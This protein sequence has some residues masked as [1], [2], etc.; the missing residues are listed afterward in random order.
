M[1]TVTTHYRPKRTPRKKRKQPPLANRIVTAKL[2]PIKEP[3]IRLGADVRSDENTAKAQRSSA[4]VEPKR[5]RDLGV[6]QPARPDGG[7]IPARR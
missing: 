2:K 1:T 5:K 4:I 6:R 7:G 3:V